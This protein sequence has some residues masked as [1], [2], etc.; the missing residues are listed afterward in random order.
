ME[1]FEIICYNIINKAFSFADLS[2]KEAVHGLVI[3]FIKIF[4]G[5]DESE[6]NLHRTF[7]SL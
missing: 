2:F 1:K 6:R 5:N 3:V 7:D 4:G